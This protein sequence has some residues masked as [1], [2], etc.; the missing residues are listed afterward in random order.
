MTS[1]IEG[2]DGFR[3]PDGAVTSPGE[4]RAVHLT[5]ATVV[6]SW[7]RRGITV[8]QLPLAIGDAAQRFCFA[9]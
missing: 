2:C 6:L 4:R 8:T 1:T 3:L 5:E 7:G 9:K